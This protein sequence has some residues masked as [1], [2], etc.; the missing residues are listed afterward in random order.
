MSDV[1]DGAM[2][3]A[4]GGAGAVAGGAIAAITEGNLVLGLVSSAAAGAIL[5]GSIALYLSARR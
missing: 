1:P 2:I 4:A 3:G 5:S